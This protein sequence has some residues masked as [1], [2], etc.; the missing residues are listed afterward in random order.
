MEDTTISIF[1][2]SSRKRISVHKYRLQNTSEIEK[3]YRRQLEFCEKFHELRWKRAFIEIKE[4]GGL[5]HCKPSHRFDSEKKYWLYNC[6]ETGIGFEWVD[7]PKE[8][9]NLELGQRFYDLDS[10]SNSVYARRRIF[11][12]ALERALEIVID[13]ET[14]SKYLCSEESAGKQLCLSINGRNYWY[15]LKQE[16][17]CQIWTKL[18]WP[19]NNCKHIT[20]Y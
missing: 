7:E 16:R 20:V 6:D 15:Y 10:Y 1:D 3:R 18:S 8:F 19:D 9:I 5:A 17:G 2:E 12:V 14:G 4:N 13:R 11:L